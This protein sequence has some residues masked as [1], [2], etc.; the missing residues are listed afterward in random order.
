MPG[1]AMSIQQSPDTEI[2]FIRRTCVV[3]P[4][5]PAE[6]RGA[7]RLDYD[8]SRSHPEIMSSP[9]VLYARA[10][11]PRFL[12]ELKELLRIPSVSTLPEH[13]ADVRRAAE[14]LA[15]EMKRIGLENVRLIETD[16]G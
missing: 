16:G 7:P 11:Q 9:A 8:R 1:P 5:S 10:N 3:T 14:T 2:Y 15:A 13:A 6:P 4:S 12:N